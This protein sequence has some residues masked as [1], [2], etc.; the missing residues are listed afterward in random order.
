MAKAQCVTTHASRVQHTEMR[1][2]TECVALLP[3]VSLSYCVADPIWGVCLYTLIPTIWHQSINDDDPYGSRPPVR[4]GLGGSDFDQIFKNF[5][6]NAKK[7][8]NNVVVSGIRIYMIIIVFVIYLK[9]ASEFVG[10]FDSVAGS[11]HN[12]FQ[13]IQLLVI[14]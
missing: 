14:S 8:Y 4:P 5:E 2:H 10:F 9:A 12:R 6:K 13:P 7:T 3:N 11:K 1:E